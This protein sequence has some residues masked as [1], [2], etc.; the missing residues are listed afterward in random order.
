MRMAVADL[1]EGIE[2]AVVASG[3]VELM[4]S[5]V[6]EEEVEGAAEETVAVGG[7]EGVEVVGIAEGAADEHGGTVTDVAGDERIWKGRLADV[8]ESCVD[9]VAKVEGG[10]D[11]RAVE[12]E[13]EQAGRHTNHGAS[14]AAPLTTAERRSLVVVDLYVAGTGPDFESWAAAVDGGG[15]VVA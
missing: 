8:G 10:I 4:G 14:V 15:E 5:I 6:G 3:V 1:G 2:D 11:K 12:V 7:V 9:G 13:D